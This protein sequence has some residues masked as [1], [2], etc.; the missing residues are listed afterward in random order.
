LSE[1]NITQQC[2][3]WDATRDACD[4]GST[5]IN[6]IVDLEHIPFPANVIFPDATPDVIRNSKLLLAPQHFGNDSQDLL[7]SFHSFLVRTS[8]HT[9][10]VDLCCGND[11]NR[12]TRP[13]WHMQSGPFLV[14]L[15]AVGVK[16]EDIDFV[17]CT[18]LHS[19]H[20]GWNT[21]LDD[22]RW[23]PTFPNAQYL[24]AEKEVQYWKQIVESGQGEN[25]LYGSY[26][27]SILPV[28]NSGQ[29]EFV[30]GSHVVET[31]I[32]LE[33]AFGH[34]PG[35]VIINV[36]SNG[37]KA[38]LSGDVIHHPVQL[39][40]PKWSTNF[41]INAE[42]SRVTRLTLLNEYANTNTLFLPAHF[43]TPEFGRIER[44]GNTYSMAI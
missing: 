30:T 12:P 23:I 40:H 26:E 15:A 19:D 1:G 2:P 39:A 4:V 25:V 3:K 20:V 16:P 8:S 18:H 28:I 38:I 43:Q 27:D 37:K 34:T 42:Q 11:K 22:G 6:R 32:Y 17:M 9:I 31:G 13:A 29:A 14:N 36:E 5:L 44:D 21:R 33:P 7:L 10:L 35:N 41:C 24:F